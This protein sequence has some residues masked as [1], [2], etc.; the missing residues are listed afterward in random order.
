[1]KYSILLLAAASLWCAEESTRTI[2]KTFPLTGSDRSLFVCGMNGTIGITAADSNEVRFTVREKL[3]AS[4]RDRLEELKKETGVVFT[5]EPGAVRA[6]VKGPW[7]NTDCADRNGQS[8]R[9]GRRRWEGNET[10]IEH[11]FTVSV[12]RD[13]ALEIRNVNGSI[14]LTGTT[15]NYR[16][17]TVNG[18]IQMN[19]VEGAGTVNT[20]NGRIQAVYRQNPR[21]DT[22]FRTVNGKLDLYFQPSLNADFKMKTVNGKAFTDFDMAPIAGSAGSSDRNQDMKVIHRRGTLGELRAGSG[23]TRIGLETVNGEILIHSLAKGRP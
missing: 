6:G 5:N 15:G 8:H 20:V 4:S 3:S 18:G 21:A 16:V 2:E 23:G 17:Q 19:D 11:E 9:E 12:P 7:S 10:R 14:H 1:M 13:A 22:Q